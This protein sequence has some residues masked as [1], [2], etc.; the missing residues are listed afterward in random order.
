MDEDGPRPTEF[1]AD[2]R[3]AYIVPL[4]RPETVAEG[5]ADTPSLNDVHDDELFV[6]YSMT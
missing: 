6:E 1:T 5:V 2:I 3:N 4:V